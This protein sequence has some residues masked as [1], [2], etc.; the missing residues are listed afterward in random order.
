MLFAEV[1]LAQARDN[2]EKAHRKVGSRSSIG[3]LGELEAFSRAQSG[4]TSDENA[5]AEVS[6]AA[7]ATGR[8]ATPR[9]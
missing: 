3:S 8:G 5:A 2:R 1:D 6:R 4:V 9:L 7:D